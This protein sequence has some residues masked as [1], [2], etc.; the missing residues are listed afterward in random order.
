MD[1]PGTPQDAVGDEG[2]GPVDEA[3]WPAHNPLAG[4]WR[5]KAGGFPD[6]AAGSAEFGGHY[7]SPSPAATGCV[8]APA[9]TVFGP[10]AAVFCIKTKKTS[11]TL[12]CCRSLL[13][14]GRA[15]LRFAP[16]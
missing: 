2:V 6:G 9:N 16:I 10:L 11:K 12:D 5:G 13:H 14:T 4:F 7:S 3:V 15:L 1:S 8:A